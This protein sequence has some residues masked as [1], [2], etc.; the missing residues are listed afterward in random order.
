MNTD[1]LSQFK[2]EFNSFF[3]LVLLN[4]AFGALAMAFG[5]QYMIMAVL[6]LPLVQTSPS[7]RVL[8]GAISLA[9]FGLGF[10]W[11]L[12][13]TKILRGIKGIRRE[14][15][16]HEGPVPDETL[17]GWIVR[18]LAHYRENKKIIPWMITISR[19][20]GCC[21]VTLGIVN[22]LQGVT[23]WNAG[24]NWM[25]MALPFMAAAINLTLGIATIAISIGF[26]R[27]AHAWDIRLAETARNETLLE[28]TLEHR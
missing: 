25:D 19:L 9:G 12:S 20:G 21:F 18:M 23:A 4:M 17:T 28:Q 15:R 2:S 11:I 27:Y 24:G 14:F 3:M 22:I 1:T 6:G 10:M 16:S 5:M 7:L 8:A 26:H 13:S